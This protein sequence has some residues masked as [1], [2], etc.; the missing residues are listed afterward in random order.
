MRVGEIRRLLMDACETA[1]MVDWNERGKITAYLDGKNDIFFTELELDSL[2]VMEICIAIELN[3]GVSIVPEQL[4]QFTTMNN[5]VSRI[6]EEI[7]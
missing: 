4:V 2:A 5:L 7:E 3:I 6:L 1:H